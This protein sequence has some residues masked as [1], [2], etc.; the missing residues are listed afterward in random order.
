MTFSM[1]ASLVLVQFVSLRVVNA[2]RDAVDAASSL[3]RY[4]SVI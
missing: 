2:S 1:L 3:E 4:Q